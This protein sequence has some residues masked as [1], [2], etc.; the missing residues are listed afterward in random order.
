MFCVGAVPR[1][2][3]RSIS[4]ELVHWLRVADFI[5]DELQQRF[6]SAVTPELFA[7]FDASIDLFH[8]GFHVRGGDWE[9]QLTVLRVIHSGLLVLK[10]GQR[11]GHE[12]AGT[13]VPICLS[14]SSHFL[15]S[16]CEVH[17]HARHIALPDCRN[18]PDIVRPALLDR[19][20]RHRGGID[21]CQ[22]MDEV[23]DGNEAIGLEMAFP[24][25][26]DP[27]LAIAH[28]GFTFGGKESK[29]PSNARQMS[30]EQLAIVAGCY[31]IP[32]DH[33]GGS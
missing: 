3:L 1:L 8:R 27:V 20:T 10:R 2:G 18:P 31:H 28:E 5:G 22:R 25:G 24:F 29:R 6:G 17:N 32:I 4:P 21:M 16:L 15:L 23:Q 12:H 26:P 33:L 9:S 30:S 19:S 11:F 13:S 14:E 7:S